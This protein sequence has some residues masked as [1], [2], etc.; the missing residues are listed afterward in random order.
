[1]DINKLNYFFAAA[2][3][4]NFT[5]AAERCHIAQTTM[6]KYIRKIEN[7]V[8]CDLFVRTNKD[9]YLT[10]QGKTFY[11]QT[12]ALYDE[13]LEIIRSIDGEEAV[14]IK[15]GIE[16]DINTTNILDAFKAE[17]PGV[18]LR[19]SFGGRDS[20]LKALQRRKIDAIIAPSHKPGD[21]DKYSGTIRVDMDSREELLVCPRKLIE[22]F[23]SLGAAIAG[24]PLI[25]KSHDS[26]YHEY[27]RKVLEELYGG[28]FKEVMEVDSYS[29]QRLL[30]EMANG[31]AIVSPEEAKGFDDIITDE[32]QGRFKNK[33]Q[34]VYMPDYIPEGLTS[35][36]SFI[37]KNT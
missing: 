3:L 4:C 24:S 2:E 17:N 29:R 28:L 1:M 21:S 36:I 25:T 23:G 13:W 9:C 34:L 19:I 16:G 11:E 37:E 5:R 12:K 14:E 8:G 26:G 35:L 7:E 6:S 31:F 33:I 27:V 30:V 32:A 22:E 10:E 15:L 20:L 18:K